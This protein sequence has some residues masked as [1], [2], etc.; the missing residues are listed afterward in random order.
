M[1]DIF[2]LFAKIGSTSPSQQAAV[3]HI[4]VGLGNPGDKY[5]HTRHN[6]GF[7][8]LDYITQKLGVKVD[9]V[10]F[11]SLCGEGTLMGKRVLFMK[12][13][14]F[15][16]LSGE[17]VREAAAFYKIAPENILV[18]CDDINFDVGIFKIKRNGSDGGQ[19]GMKN[20]IYQLASD[21]FPRIKIGVGKKPSPDY[22]LADFVLG[23]FSEN[24]KKVLF[25]TFE[26]VY[27][28]CEKIIDGHIDDA[29]SMFNKGK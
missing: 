19:N 28:A 29:M 7:L 3:T 15:M 13:Q 4:V 27:T 12:P 5:T 22:D 2:E 14:T 23:K 21:K 24:D 26:K 25:A 1:A 6:S 18:I 16:N 10:K 11:K 17:A 9:R 8:A 20:I